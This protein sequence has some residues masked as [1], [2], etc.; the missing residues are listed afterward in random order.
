MLYHMQN[1]F[2]FLRFQNNFKLHVDTQNLMGHDKEKVN[3]SEVSMLFYLV[4]FL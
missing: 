3:G 1:H 4:T 2:V